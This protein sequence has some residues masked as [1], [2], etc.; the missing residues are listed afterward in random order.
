M[1]IEFFVSRL[2]EIGALETDRLIL[3]RFQET[4]SEDMFLYAGDEDVTKTLT[5][6]TYN[7]VDECK[8]Y[9]KN[10]SKNKVNIYAIELKEEKKVI[11]SIDLRFIPEDDKCSFG[12][13]LSKKYWNN[14]YATE[15]LSK[16]I[17]IVFKE[18]GANKIEACH[19]DGND[20][21]GK[22]M[23]KCG[24][25]YEGT[26]VQTRLVKGNYVDSVNYGILRENYFLKI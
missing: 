8:D 19:F 23:K 15:A 6:T 3:R 5:F 25:E 20:S 11:G 13:V 2:K 1:E 16:I 18:I 21:S 4:D 12:Y 9:I 24:M 7:N 14:G 17:E 22:V 10:F 26:Q